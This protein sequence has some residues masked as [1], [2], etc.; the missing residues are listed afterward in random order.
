MYQGL[1]KIEFHGVYYSETGKT[2]KNLNARLVNLVFPN[3]H[4]IAFTGKVSTL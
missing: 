4:S 3:K 1:M 2:A